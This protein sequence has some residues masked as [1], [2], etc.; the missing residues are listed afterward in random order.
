[1]R[2]SQ[3]WKINILLKRSGEFVASG[4]NGGREMIGGNMVFHPLTVASS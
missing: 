3:F 2:K 4:Y 1:V